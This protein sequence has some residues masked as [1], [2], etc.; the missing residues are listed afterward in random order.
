[1]A[2]HGRLGEVEPSI[3]R[4][5]WHQG[6]ST[7]SLSGDG[8]SVPLRLHFASHIAF[9]AILRDAPTTGYIE[10]IDELISELWVESFTHAYNVMMVLQ[11]RVWHRFGR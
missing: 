4:I 7:K 8:S 5:E 2:E 3:G 11:K 6:A 10:A 1:M 9:A